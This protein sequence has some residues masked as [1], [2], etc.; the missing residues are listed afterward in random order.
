M[1]STTQSLCVDK[2]EIKEV[3]E[4]E[5]GEFYTAQQAI[6]Y[7]YDKLIQLRMELSDSIN[8][9]NPK[10]LC[11][12][13]HV[14]VYIAC[15]RHNDDKK[16]YF[17]HRIE[18]GNCPAITRSNFTKEQIEA[19]KYNG[20][21][22]SPAHYRMKEIIAESLRNDSNFSD[23]KIETVIKG[24]DRK[25]WRKPDIQA[26]WQGKLRVAFEVQL[27]TT[28]LQV[29]SQRRLFYKATGGLVVWV[30][31]R[32]DKENALMTQDDIFHN[33]NQN[34]FIVNEDTLKESKQ[35]KG[36]MFNC[37]WREPQIRSSH[38]VNEWNS[39][40]VKFNE[41]EWNL[42]RQSIYYYD[43][44][45]EYKRLENKLINGDLKERFEEWWIKHDHSPKY[46]D[47]WKSFVDEFRNKDIYIPEYPSEVD[48]LISSLYSAK[49]ER[50]IGFR[51]QKFIQVAH[52]VADLKNNKSVLKIFRVALYV[53]QRGNLI[54]EQ[55]K[56]GKWKRKSNEFRKKIYS[57]NEYDRDKSL[58]SLMRFLFPELM[59]EEVW[60]RLKEI[61]KKYN[62]SN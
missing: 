8:S 15:N 62:Q 24:A 27:S 36:L 3:L 39:K 2:P 35:H 60:I 23:I 51:Y 37:H 16:F 20:A 10:Y 26:L 22:E 12:I 1:S 55:D 33:N 14:P 40:Y 5:T 61:D 34:L 54:I 4:I 52:M 58:D 17:K 28:F 59:K 6:G 38:I 48:N 47:E 19:I 9:G 49:Y 21:K 46:N 11:P 30:F 56:E 31:R 57:S 32:F 29:I 25:Q 43:Y 41:L 45:G 18:D 44:G 53:Y 50:V 7:D 42:D 13:C